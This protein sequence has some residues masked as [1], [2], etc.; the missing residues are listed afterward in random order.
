M[1]RL[2]TVSAWIGRYRAA[3][4]SNDPA[5]IAGLFTPTAEY[6]PEPYAVPWHGRD[7]IVAGWL[8]RPREPGEATFEW[9][10]VAITDYV[11]VVQ[12]STVHPDKKFSHMWVIHL[13]NVGDCQVFTE[14]R[15]QQP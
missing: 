9:H 5:D 10:P 2:N 14:W 12:G 7:A 4:E 3:C 6:F 11:A 1:T 8:A 13:D 15:M